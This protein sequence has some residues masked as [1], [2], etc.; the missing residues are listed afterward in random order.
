[1]FLLGGAAAAQLAGRLMDR[2]GRMK[3]VCAGFLVG[4]TGCIVVRLAI[5]WHSTELSLLGFVL[6]GAAA[7]TIMLA[8]LAGADMFPPGRGGRGISLVLLGAVVGGVL[9][10]VA[11]LP[12]A[13]AHSNDGQTLAQAWLGGA[14]GLVLGALVSLTV[15]P[16]PKKIAERIAGGA[17]SANLAGSPTSSLA[18]ILRRPGVLVA[19]TTAVV[20]HALMVAL[21][22][23]C[24]YLMVCHGHTPAPIFVVVGTHFVGM[25]GMILV[26]GEVSDRMG[27]GRAMA[28]GLLIICGVFLSLPW[29]HSSWAFGVNMFMLGWGWNF[30]FV[31]ATSELAQATKPYE[32]GRLVG[33]NDVLASMLGAVLVATAGAVMQRAGVV[34]LAVAGALVTA[35]PLLLIARATHGKGIEAT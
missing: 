13:A 11:F 16:D 20:A 12:L 8:R 9:G 5:L 27:H 3:V 2:F 25:F 15:R 23:L 19:L 31:A 18:E 6:A 1:V 33:F 14:A 29:V 4:A 24:G 22:S 7:G 10:P 28:L 21:M 17:V 35:A 34:P 32:R 30:A 26:S